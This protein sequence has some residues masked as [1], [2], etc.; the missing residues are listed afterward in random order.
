M[1][2]VRAYIRSGKELEVDRVEGLSVE[3]LSLVKKMLKVNPSERITWKKLQEELTSILGVEP[4]RF[5]NTKTTFFKHL[6]LLKIFASM[7]V[8][9]RKNC[10]YNPHVFWV[11]NKVDLQF[12]A[13]LL[14]H[15]SYLYSRRFKS[16][17]GYKVNDHLQP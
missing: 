10:E 3:L 5:L 12:I 14:I 6:K 4:E 9:I 7:T 1:E 2:A 17:F 11:G 13:D 8:I 16:L 15:L